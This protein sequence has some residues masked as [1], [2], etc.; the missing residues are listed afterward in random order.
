LEADPIVTAPLLAFPVEYMHGPA[1]L[2][3]KMAGQPIK[4]IGSFELTL[5]LYRD[6][7][8]LTVLSD[9]VKHLP[10]AAI[11]PSTTPVA[12]ILTSIAQARNAVD[13]D[14]APA[15]RLT[16]DGRLREQLLTLAEPHRSQMLQILDDF[17]AAM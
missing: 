15:A 11:L 2:S 13:S 12:D 6:F 16:A 10:V 1:L 5:H 3:G 7:E 14:D 17:I 9:S 4:G 8:L